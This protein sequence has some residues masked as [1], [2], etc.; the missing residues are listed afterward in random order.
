LA[1]VRP[2]RARRVARSREGRFDAGETTRVDRPR[3]QLGF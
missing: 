3:Q 2:H 1:E